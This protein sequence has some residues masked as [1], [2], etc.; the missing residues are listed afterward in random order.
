VLP[1]QQRVRL[2]QLRDMRDQLARLFAEELVALLSRSVALLL[3][4]LQ[5]A[6]ELL[7]NLNV[8]SLRLLQLLVEELRLLVLLLLQLA[9]PLHLLLLP[10][11]VLPLLTLNLSLQTLGLS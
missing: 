8:L 1:L 7:D 10:D 2:L 6:L 5:L 3:Q 4:P 11:C 9:E